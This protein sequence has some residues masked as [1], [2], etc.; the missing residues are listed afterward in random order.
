MYV[1][2]L[3][4]KRE[5]Y[6]VM[7]MSVLFLEYRVS[8]CMLTIG[9]ENMYVK[10]RERKCACMLSIGADVCSVKYKT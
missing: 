8:V 4:S 7:G 6:L 2:I 10:F 5:W 3:C 9:A 1:C